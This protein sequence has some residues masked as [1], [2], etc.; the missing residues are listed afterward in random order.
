MKILVIL[1]LSSCIVAESQTIAPTWIRKYGGMVFETSSNQRFTTIS[2][3]S[4]FSRYL[5]LVDMQTLDV[6]VSF[7]VHIPHL[8]S[9]FSPNSRYLIVHGSYDNCGIWFSYF[10]CYDIQ[11]KKWLCKP[12]VSQDQDLYDVHCS[13]DGSYVYYTTQ[14]AHI[15]ERGTPVTD[16]IKLE[17]SIDT[18]IAPTSTFQNINK[19]LY[20]KFD[21][22]IIP[23]GGKIF[24]TISNYPSILSVRLYS[25]NSGFCIDS[26]ILNM[27]HDTSNLLSYSFHPTGKYIFF[28]TQHK[29]KRNKQ[30]FLYDIT[31]KDYLSTTMYSSAFKQSTFNRKGNELWLS[32]GHSLFV[33]SFPEGTLKRT[34]TLDTILS[35][36]LGADGTYFIVHGI[37]NE[38]FN[39]PY[40][41][42]IYITSKMEKIRDLGVRE[43]GI[44]RVFSSNL[45][46]AVI[47][48]KDKLLSTIINTVTGDT[49]KDSVVFNPGE[50]CERFGNQSIINNMLNEVFYDGETFEL[51]KTVSI[52][53]PLQKIQFI[54]DT[55]K[56]ILIDKQNSIF[57]FELPT[58]HTSFTSGV[59][60]TRYGVVDNEY[61][62]FNNYGMLNI[63]DVSGRCVISNEVTE[64]DNVVNI[65][66]L[67]NGVYVATVT[68]ISE[69]FKMQ[70]IVNK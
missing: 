52:A 19:L 58:Q 24:Y 7:D 25:I 9:Q 14:Y 23:D 16:S 45:D 65:Q 36:E 55:R 17:Q 53:L 56:C 21:N 63:Y 30:L 29:T 35:F 69:T 64:K 68:G 49:L 28:S 59:S 42:S 47:H 3:Y 31:K 26:S 38:Q 62:T 46:K 60:E 40:I 12:Y 1:L 15:I 33:H 34:L 20:A 48:I 70:F 57:L 66:R 39:K 67:Q 6:L 41:S 61:L 37:D 2:E 32:D 18:S 51:H 44:N 50:N 8:Y 4:S 22:I 13:D 43:N 11:I 5:S 54:P 10:G 27:Q